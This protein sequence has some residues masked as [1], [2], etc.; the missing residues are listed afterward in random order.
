MSLD[1]F[2]AEPVVIVF[3][4]MRDKAL[5]EMMSILFPRAAKVI[6]TTLDNPRAASIA[7]MIAATP[8]GL[9]SQIVRAASLGEALRLARNIAAPNG[10]VCVTGS[11]HLI[12]EAQQLLEAEP[13]TTDR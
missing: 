4:A 11:L 13:G 1:E 10:I 6:L 12:G 8:D 9:Q 2:I 7:E 5:R 3:G